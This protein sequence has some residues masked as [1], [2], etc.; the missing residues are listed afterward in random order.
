MTVNQLLKKIDKSSL[1]HRTLGII[2]T[3]NQTKGSAADPSAPAGPAT[4]LAILS[5]QV[6]VKQYEE[7]GKEQT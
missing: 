6:L 2:F 4:L 5:G 3:C 7:V 1:S